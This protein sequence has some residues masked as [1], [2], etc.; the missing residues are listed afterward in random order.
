MKYIY[1]LSIAACMMAASN[2]LAIE[3]EEISI[4]MVPLAA[5]MSIDNSYP[6]SK[7]LRAWR[8][9][10]NGKECY[11]ISMLQGDQ[12]VDVYVSPDGSVIARKQKNASIDELPRA[13]IDDAFI[14]LL[15]G[16]LAGAS[17]RWLLQIV[18][19]ENALILSELLSAWLGA[20]LAIAIL[21]FAIAPRDSDFRILVYRSIVWGAISAEL[22]VIFSQ[23]VKW[24]RDR[25]ELGRQR[26]ILLLCLTM[27]GCILLTF[28][29]DTIAIERENRYNA[30]LA[31]RSVP[32]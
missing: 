26:A 8:E 21:S 13:L 22:I 14:F 20:V 28:Y 29:I 5:S 6:S 7:I 32:K 23:V 17:A 2:V 27:L 11:M 19:R 12:I 9:S 1:W 3:R 30:L 25:R 24:L 31:M 16:I 15:P 18:Q 4:D 10:E